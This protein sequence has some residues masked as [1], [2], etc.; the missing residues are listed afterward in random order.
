[1]KKILTSLAIV[2]GI[3]AIAGGA[4]L[5]FLSDTETS[6]GNTFTAGAIDLKIDNTSYYNG[7]EYPTSTW[8][9]SD[10]TGQLF[11]SFDDLKPDDQG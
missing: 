10:L 7:E 8:Q 4:T 9:A 3:G 1:M 11:F 6:S 2:V 5:A